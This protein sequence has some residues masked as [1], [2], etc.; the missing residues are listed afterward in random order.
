M[1]AANVQ[2]LR[3]RKPDAVKTPAKLRHTGVL[4]DQVRR[5]AKAP[6]TPNFSL[7]FR[8]I[9]LVRF[10]AAMYSNIQDCDEVYN[11]WEPLH[12]LDRGVGFQT[13]E[14][15]PQYAIRS[16]AYIVLHLI[17]AWGPV[18]LLRLE[19]R[20][21]FFAVRIFL[22]VMSTFCEAKLYRAVVETL[23]DRVGRYMLFM[24][25]FSAGMWNS[26]TSFLPSSFAMYA[27][28]LAF[29]YAIRLPNKFDNRR[30]VLATF[31]FATG[32]IVGWPF[33]LLVSVPFV[34]EELFV[35]GSDRVP[36]TV[37][38]VWQISRVKRL[39]LS[40]LM[41][42]SLLVPVILVD[43]TAY[44]RSVVVPW[45]IIKYN[46]FGGTERGPE[47]YGSEP[48]HFYVFNLLLNFNIL[49][50]FALFSL[51]ALSV[52]YF[53]DRKRLGTTAPG[54]DQ[55]SPF[56][57]MAMRL[58]PLYLWFGV[59]TAQAH[60]E[61]R[62]MYPAYPLICLNAAICLYLVRGW[63][64]T[65][66]IRITSSPYQASRSSIFRL[67]TLFVVSTSIVISVSRILALGHYYHAPLHVA[68]Q[69][70]TYELP[71][72][73]N[74]T[75][76]LD[77]P[78]TVDGNRDDTGV[79]IDLS[80]IK[81]FGLRLCLGKEWYRFP[82]HYLIPDGVDVRFIKSDFDGLLPRR[83]DVSTGEGGFWKREAT[84]HVPLGLNDLNKEDKSHYVDISTCDYLID[85]DF[86]HHPQTSVYEPRYAVDS[87]T[88]DRVICVPF[89]DA[90]HSSV[91]TRTLWLPIPYWSQRNSF[92][93]YCLL[94]QKQRAKKREV[95]P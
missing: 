28:M 92:G 82:G 58:L 62:F 9:L 20:Q 3:L 83:F 74:V 39:I 78:E 27:N 91:L 26:S 55:S 85:S 45:N 4:Q 43:T 11:F 10:S 33:S 25:V 77:I 50:P 75:G 35:F 48:W 14:V 90:R 30:T 71:R 29:S 56:V 22:A 88:W 69:F 8:I 54:P 12:Y 59:L 5:T 53:V 46:I 16:W 65:A 41:A 19:K 80:P 73:L 84:R 51:P 63:V 95:H 52:T 6:W 21:A 72:L 40:G 32:A 49:I 15:S 37:R 47:L 13:W 23:N 94:R 93:E 31:F 66:F 60:K 38:G 61:E 24:L 76:F 2:T 18:R 67:T 70:E 79:R 34:L 17:P 81:Q 89:L 44:G 57:I 7:A 36:S 42:A 68:F 1:A 87:S 86:P 64:E